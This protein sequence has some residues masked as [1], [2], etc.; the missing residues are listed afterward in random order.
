MKNFMKVNPY[1]GFSLVL[2]ITTFVTLLGL[3]TL[4][5]RDAADKSVSHSNE[6]IATTDQ[7]LLGMEDMETG[8]RGYMLT[9]SDGFLDPYRSGEVKYETSLKKLLDLTP[10][11][12]SQEAR[13]KDVQTLEEQWKAD[14]VDKSLKIRQ[15]VNAG[16][17][18][19]NALFDNNL[20]E[21]GQKKM[22]AI[23]DLI[24]KAKREEADHLA[25]RIPAWQRANQLAYMVIMFGM[26]FSVIIGLSTGAILTRTNKMNKEYIELQHLL[27]EERENERK[28]IARDLHDGPLQDVIAAKFAVNCIVVDDRKP[29]ITEQLN[30]LMMSLDK[31]IAEM[32]SYAMELRSP[33]LFKFGLEKAILSHLEVFQPSHPEIQITFKAVNAENLLPPPIRETLY[34]I[35]QETMNNI[36]RHSEA[37]EVHIYYERQEAQALLE[38]RD[39]GVGFQVPSD[40]L[41]LARQGH[42]G[43]VGIRERVDAIGGQIEIIS[44]PGSGTVLRII[45]PVR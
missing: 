42:L 22:L 24:T 38:I 23:Q 31:V 36:V 29:V 32:R 14:W 1:I 35:Y 10:D 6:V 9:G 37:S 13:W 2:L 28:N 16:T 5:D 4:Q 45:I 43:L 11:D 17:A 27:L 34:R 26:A 12:T 8:L 18:S 41:S 39:N 19:S 44:H 30:N 20:A 3:K 7:L 33:V 40:W 15:D 21:S 25:V